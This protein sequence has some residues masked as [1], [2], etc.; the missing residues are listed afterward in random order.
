M[1]VLGMNNERIENNS[2]LNYLEKGTTLDI[3]K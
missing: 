1:R 3:K 2:C